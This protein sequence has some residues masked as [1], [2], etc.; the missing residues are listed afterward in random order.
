MTT[1]G[2]TTSG[3][4]FPSAAANVVATA[5]SLAQS[6]A[7]ANV[8]S[9][10]VGASDSSFIVSGNVL[11]TASVTNSFGIVITYT[12]E[13]NTPRSLTLNLSQLVGTL[14]QLVTNVL[15]TGPYSGIPAQIRCK[16]GTTITVTTAGTFT[17]VT[18]NVEGTIIQ[19]A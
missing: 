12:D 9:Y 16:A 8:T 14:I 4:T 2:A 5:R 1:F 6:A 3:T 13:S 10:V 7:V 17:S 19:V 15:G 18:Y 11:V